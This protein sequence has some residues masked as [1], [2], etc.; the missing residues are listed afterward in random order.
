MTFPILGG[1]DEDVIGWSLT[2]FLPLPHFQNSVMKSSRLSGERIVNFE[3]SLV[4]GFSLPSVFGGSMNDRM[5]RLA[6][7]SPRATRT[8]T[9]NAYCS[10]RRGVSAAECDAVEA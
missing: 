3:D 8:K 5:R 1:L 9:P 7:F 4:Y 6:A 10:I 2:F